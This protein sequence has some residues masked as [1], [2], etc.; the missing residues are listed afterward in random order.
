[1]KLYA[2]SGLGADKRVFD[3]LVLDHELIAIDWIEPLE[4][5]SIHAYALRL[6]EAIDQSTDYAILGLSFGGLIAVE[7]S[8]VLKPKRTIL[9]S[10]AETCDDLRPLYRFLGRTGLVNILADFFFV[11]PGWLAQYFFGTKEGKL[12]QDILDDTDPKF[13]KWAIK[14]LLSWGNTQKLEHVLKIGGSKDK[15]IPCKA[16]ANTKLIKGGAHFMIVDRADEISRIINQELR[17]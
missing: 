15:L 8:K 1:M 13:S 5:E 11:P 6:S 14:Q 3:R 10:S 4:E 2:I 12:L 7:I 9:V 16:D 17:K